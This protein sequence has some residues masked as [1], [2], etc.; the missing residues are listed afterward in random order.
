MK[1]VSKPSISYG[2]EAWRSDYTFHR[3][4]LDATPN[5]I[6]PFVSRKQAITEGTLLV[7]KAISAPGSADSGIFAVSAGEF[8]GFP[9]RTPIERSTGV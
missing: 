3:I 9:I 8:K 6:T 5:K 2:D 1:N 4:M 7:M